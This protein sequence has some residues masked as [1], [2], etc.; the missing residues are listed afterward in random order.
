MLPCHCMRFR[1]LHS[2][3]RQVLVT[4]SYHSLILPIQQPSLTARSRPNPQTSTTQPTARLQLS[5]QQN[6][7]PTGNML[8]QGPVNHFLDGLL[9]EYDKHVRTSGAYDKQAKYSLPSLTNGVLP[10][11]LSQ[12]ATGPGQQTRGI[13]PWLVPA[14][15]L[16]SRLLSEDY[17]L[18][19]F[20]HLTFGERRRGTT[21]MYI[22]PTAFLTSPQA[23]V[24]VR[25][26]IRNVGELTTLM[27]APQH[28]RE[29]G[30]WG[31]TTRSKHHQK[32]YKAFRN[33]HWPPLN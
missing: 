17:P 12:W 21:G 5:P 10:M 11:F 30:S 15:K 25:D 28:H 16:A 31:F 27:F 6:H 29:S 24:R 9:T 18:M 13:Y 8:L 2:L 7:N 22:L 3:S 1:P 19:W 4:I 20:C 26:N 33:S 23:I 32:F 14:F